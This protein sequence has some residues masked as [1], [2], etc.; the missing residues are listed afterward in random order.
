MGNGA[1]IV[2]ARFEQIVEGEQFIG[3]VFPVAELDYDIENRLRA[4]EFIGSIA[5]S[6]SEQS[7]QTP[8]ESYSLADALQLAA[9]NDT[10][11]RQMVRVNVQ[12]DVIERVIKS[13][14]ITRV[15]LG[16]NEYGKI[17]QYG[18]TNEDIQKNSLKYAAGSSQMKNR[19]KAETRNMMRI[20]NLYDRGLLEDYAFVVFSR[21]ADDMSEEEMSDIG[22]FTD[23]MSCAIQVTTVTDGQLMVESA[24]VAGKTSWDAPRHDAAT[25]TKLGES[26]D[27]DLGD[28][29]ATE[30]LDYPILIHKS[31]LEN[32]VVDLVKLYDDSADGTFFG[33]AKP[34]QDYSVYAQECHEREQSLQEQVD[35]V[36]KK[37]IKAATGL[38]TARAASR[39]LAKLSQDAMVEHSVHDTRID[40]RVF[41]AEAAFRIEHA[42]QLASTGQ[43]DIMQQVLTQAKMV[44][45]SSSCPGGSNGNNDVDALLRPNGLDNS[46]DTATESLEDCEFVSKECPICHEKNVKTVVKK[47]K[48]YGECGCSA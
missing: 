27:V 41:G 18:Q 35:T 17:T 2:E 3:P 11:A 34:R 39:Y 20:Q 46:D 1:S 47:G 5:V 12:K 24:F 38:K 23:T 30:L 26:L 15:K 25:L 44:A 14:H 8:D 33:E 7:R 29:T 48:Y 37:L 45:R 19:T 22:F 6:A 10:E 13:G 43:A 42:R 9:N 40:A 32:G 36:V 31:R 28:K 4:A 21:A 16:V